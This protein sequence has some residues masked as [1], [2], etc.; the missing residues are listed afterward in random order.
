[1]SILHNYYIGVETVEL[2]M[3]GV[4]AAVQLFNDGNWAFE[5]ELTGY[6]IIGV[7]IAGFVLAIACV[8]CGKRK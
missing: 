8:L 2:L 6:T 4:V 7:M 3:I 1:M 5:L